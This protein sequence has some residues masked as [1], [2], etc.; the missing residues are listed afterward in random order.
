MTR[1]VHGINPGSR[2]TV[3]ATLISQADP[4]AASVEFLTTSGNT[5]P[6]PDGS[7]VAGSWLGSWSSSTGKV[8]ALSPT[9]GAAGSDIELAAEGEYVLWVRWTSGAARPVEDVSTLSFGY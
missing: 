6:D 2:Q 9:V 7:W 1:P 3:R 4:T 5:D 8:E